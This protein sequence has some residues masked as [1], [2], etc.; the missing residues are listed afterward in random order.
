MMLALRLARLA[1]ATIALV[2][3][4]AFLA[5]FG[6]LLLGRGG[7]GWFAFVRELTL[8]LFLPLPLVLLAAA[9]IRSRA[10]LVLS[11]LP[12][13]VFLGYYGPR[14]GPEPPAAAGTSG[15]FRVL[16]FNAG[17]NAGGG[18]LAPLARTIR[19]VDAD[20]VA[21]QEVS[22]G[23]LAA[24]REDLSSAY[25][26]QIGSSDTVTLSRF[27]LQPGTDLRLGDSP[28]AG[29]QVRI[30][31]RGREVVLTNVHV[32]RPGYRL[33]W[34]R[35]VV[36]LVRSY[37]PAARDAQVAEL[38]QQ[39]RAVGGPRLLTGDFNETEWSRP[40]QLITAELQDS[41]RD[42]GHGFGHTYPSN[43]IWGSW[44]FSLPLM[45]IDYVF[46]SAELDATRAWVGPDGGSDHL[47]VVAELVFR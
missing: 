46:H 7:A 2:Y 34:R 35:G 44:H 24:L 33:Q 28:Y 17:G 20:V 21:L 39:V 6:V 10:T 1:L 8:Y 30:D 31:A 47:P 11:L 41:Y 5:Y 19:T 15:A 22:N 27:P 26:Y 37:N 29:Q 32:T 40:Y 16:T 12:L 43:F 42:A 23:T 45:R 9:L 38:V 14:F 13:A 4:V 36:P 18:A 3:L 25:P